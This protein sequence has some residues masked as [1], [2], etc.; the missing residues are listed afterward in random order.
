[1][2]PVSLG[3]LPSSPATVGAVNDMLLFPFK[4][5][6][7]VPVMVLVVKVISLNAAQSA[8]DAAPRAIVA[9]LVKA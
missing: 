8:V 5:K 6:L 1:M 3:C 9:V 2:P 7:L 4:S